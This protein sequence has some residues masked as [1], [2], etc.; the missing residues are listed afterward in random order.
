MY[1]YLYIYHS[2][3]LL[4]TSTVIQSIP[5]IVAKD[6]I[7]FVF[8]VA[9]IFQ[10]VFAGM[11]PCVEFY[12]SIIQNSCSYNVYDALQQEDLTVYTQTMW[13]NNS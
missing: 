6:Y 9:D 8:T 2:Y 5:H 13:T 1:I 10:R 3:L 11:Y 12:S 4:L 7:I